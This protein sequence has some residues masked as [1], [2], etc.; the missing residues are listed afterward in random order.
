MSNLD[1]FKT[2]ILKNKLRIS[3]DSRI[4][5]K[6]CYFVPIKGEVFDGHRFV[7]QALKN[8][9]AG[10]LEE[11]ELYELVKFKLNSV[12][13]KIIGVTGSSGK[14][15]V[16]GFLN[17][18]F[19][20]KYKTCLGYLNT[21]LG[22][23]TNVI[24]DMRMDCEY[25]I[26][27]MGMD[28]TG[29]LEDTTKLIP[30]DIAMITTINETHLEKLKTLKNI[31]EAK[32]E[33][34]KH[35]KPRGLLV[36][37]FDNKL[38]RQYALKRNFR[39]KKVWFSSKDYNYKGFRVLGDHNKS[40]LMGC[41]AIA[42]IS[43]FNE[44]TLRRII[45]KLTSPKGRLN[46][47]AGKN[48][49]VLLDDTYNASPAS[50]ITALEALA[51]FQSKRKIVILGDMLEL[52]RYEVKG[53]R[54]VA[55]KINSIKPDIL[56]TVGALGKIIFKYSRIPNKQHLDKST[57]IRKLKKT[58]YPQKGDVIL[59]KGSQGARME[60]ITEYFLKKSDK[61]ENVLVRQD[62]RWT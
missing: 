40:N 12:K 60:K 25:F 42:K 62:P 30:P 34:A 10:I 21:K 24:N 5:S 54:L 20:A 55:E 58:T 19:S 32:F 59:I 23:S 48:G 44:S 3:L 29:E 8:R 50:T 41:V 11:K 26:A 35:I 39:H 49:C 18:I 47:L 9:A 56:V 31:V 16:T 36:L 15:T 38:I 4:I 33:I 13:P 17:T 37:N 28:H 46:A 53:H 22:L 14:T 57:D 27:E 52:G 61:P 45:P 1:R 7:D 43:G 2:L 51:N 6:N